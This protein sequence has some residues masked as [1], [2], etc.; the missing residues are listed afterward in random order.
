ATYRTFYQMEEGHIP[1]PFALKST[2]STIKQ[3]MT[4]VESPAFKQ[5]YNEQ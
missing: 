5:N 3:W 2:L 4:D 1:R